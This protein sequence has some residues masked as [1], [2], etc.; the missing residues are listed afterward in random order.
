MLITVSKLQITGGKNK[1]KAI[2]RETSSIVWLTYAIKRIIC[3]H[4]LG[5][6]LI[7][8]ECWWETGQEKQ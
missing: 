3:W 5:M 6:S 4:M 2:P 7:Y 1:K 8:S